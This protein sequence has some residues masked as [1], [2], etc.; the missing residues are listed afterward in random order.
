MWRQDFPIVRRNWGAGW[1]I[2]QLGASKCGINA[3]AVVAALEIVLRL[4]FSLFPAS[5]WDSPPIA[6]SNAS[7]RSVS[8]LAYPWGWAAF[9]ENG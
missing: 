6:S 2:R 4:P 5:A 7:S 8:R 3:I 9:Y 1:N